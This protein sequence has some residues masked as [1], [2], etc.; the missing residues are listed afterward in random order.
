MYLS[1]LPIRATC[2]THLIIILDLIGFTEHLLNQGKVN[3][4]FHLQLAITSD[5]AFYKAVTDHQHHQQ[6]QQHLA[7]T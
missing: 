6:Q 4:R 5:G 1:S 3:F 7:A 2:P